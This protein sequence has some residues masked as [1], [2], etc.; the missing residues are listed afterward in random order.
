MKEKVEYVP[1]Y[2]FGQL[3]IVKELESVFDSYGR[4]Q[5]VF[6]LMCDC[7]KTV[8]KKLNNLRYGGAKVKTCGCSLPGRIKDISGQKFGNL[9]AIR[10]TGNKHHSSYIWECVCDCG[11][12]KEV[13][14]NY[15]RTGQVKSCGCLQWQG[16]PVD[17]ENKVFGRLTAVE[18]LEQSPNAGY[19]WKCLCEC[20]NDTKVTVGNLNS[21]HT[22][23]CG[24]LQE[25][26]AKTHGMYSTGTYQ[27][28]R[29]MLD[30]TRH[31]EYEGWFGVVSVCDR[32]DTWKG[33]SFENFFEDMGERPEGC[34]LNRINGA[35]IYSKETCEWATFS[36]QSYDQNVTASNTSG[37][38]G[39][40]WREDRQVW[41]AQIT[42]DG[43][44][45]QL[46]YG[47]SFEEAC[48][49][50]EQAE[51]EYYGFYKQSE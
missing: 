32:W 16:N 19:F 31:E 29:K 22:R 35:K 1:G 42:K 20:G 39:V 10:N 44:V 48:K 6:E 15:L 46:Y 49:L 21:G 25:E 50:R 24:C 26:T 38:I 11:M 3:E 34:S 30:R 2:R 18:R 5:R 47:P 36:V 4:P 7:G 13:S 41:S 8:T 51:V 43:V 17:L 37:K 23:S 9:T 40:R 33:G 27:S 45:H 12:T 28:W 14:G